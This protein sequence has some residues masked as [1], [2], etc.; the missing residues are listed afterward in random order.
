MF[1]RVECLQCVWAAVCWRGVCWRC[2]LLC[3]FHECFG[4]TEQ[5]CCISINPALVLQNPPNYRI[6]N[7]KRFFL[8]NAKISWLLGW[9]KNECSF[10]TFFCFSVAWY[11]GTH[12]SFLLLTRP[13]WTV[14]PLHYD[15]MQLYVLFLLLVKL[16]LQ[17]AAYPYCIYH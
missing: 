10:W 2:I 1:S 17:K 6:K 15:Y 14:C 16:Q 12:L 8:M 5:I 7:L 11:D 3:V 9:F 13:K 4:L